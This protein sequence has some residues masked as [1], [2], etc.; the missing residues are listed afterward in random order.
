M[1]DYYSVIARAVSQ[2]A[3]D[4]PEARQE[5]YQRARKIVDAELHSREPRVP[6]SEILR[7]ELALEDAIRRVEAKSASLSPRPVKAR[8]RQSEK[9]AINPAVAS[10]KAKT[11]RSLI[12]SWVFISAIWCTYIAEYAHR[13]YK[14]QT[15][16]SVPIQEQ[17]RDV[18]PDQLT[19]IPPECVVTLPDE[20]FDALQ[21]PL[22]VYV[23]IGVMPPIALFGIGAIL[24][25]AVSRSTLVKEGI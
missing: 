9:L 17:C 5:L 1:T 14:I 12:L 13:D 18:V 3:M 23:I 15:P 16:P 2:L 25:W 11:R 7:Q 22:W 10:P 24:Y 19:T 4:T 8:P 21:T 20:A 6:A